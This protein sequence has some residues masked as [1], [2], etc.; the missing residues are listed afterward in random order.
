MSEPRAPSPACVCCN[1]PDSRCCSAPCPLRIMRTLR[2]FCKKE[3]EQKPSLNLYKRPC[4]ERVGGSPWIQRPQCPRRKT[5]VWAPLHA[6]SRNLSPSPVRTLG[7]EC[8]KQ[9]LDTRSAESP[10]ETRASQSLACGRRW[11]EVLDALC[12]LSCGE[13]VSV[14]AFLVGAGVCRRG[15]GPCSQP[16]GWGHVPTL[17]AESQVVQQKG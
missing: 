1:L 13:S 3:K 12:T 15:T 9:P 11:G 10:R 16:A 7:S 17:A 8:L 4:R 14:V 6:P 5:Q 2:I